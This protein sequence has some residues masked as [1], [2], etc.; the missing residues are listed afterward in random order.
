MAE[1]CTE[2]LKIR[3]TP[4][5][6]DALMR[7]SFA[8]DRSPSE[9]VRAV[10]NVHVFGH[11]RKLATEGEGGEVPNGSCEG[12]RNNSSLAIARGAA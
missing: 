1:K 8:E 6:K 10:L 12:P 9:Y 11:V 2:E 5:L 4:E 3:V 7:L